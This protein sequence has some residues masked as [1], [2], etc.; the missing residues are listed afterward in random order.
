MWRLASVLEQ[1][2]FAKFK[3][4]N[5]RCDIHSSFFEF[6]DKARIV[7]IQNVGLFETCFECKGLRQWEG[8]L[9]K[10]ERCQGKFTF[11]GNKKDL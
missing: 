7:N 4:I 5:I 11:W 2:M 9:Q 3:G 6:I 8:L 10:S 1:A